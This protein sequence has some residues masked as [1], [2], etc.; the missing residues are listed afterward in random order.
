MFNFINCEKFN[1]YILTCSWKN[2]NDINYK[3][4]LQVFKYDDINDRLNPVLLFV[5]SS[6]II[7]RNI[8][9]DRH[10][11]LFLSGGRDLWLMRGWG[12]FHSWSTILTKTENGALMR[13]T[14]RDAKS[15][16]PAKML[17]TWPIRILP[18]SWSLTKPELLRSCLSSTFDSFSWQLRSNSYFRRL[19][20]QGENHFLL[21]LSKLSRQATL[22]D[23]I[24]GLTAIS[25]RMDIAA[26]PSH[27]VA[28]SINAFLAVTLKPSWFTSLEDST[29][30]PKYVYVLSWKLHPPR[31]PASSTKSCLHL[32][33]RLSAMV[34]TAVGHS[35]Y[36]GSAMW[37]PAVSRLLR[38]AMSARM[39]F[40][41]RTIP[42][43]SLLSV[44]Q[45]RKRA[46]RSSCWLSL[47]MFASTSHCCCC[48][49]SMAIRSYSI[50]FVLKPRA[51]VIWCDGTATSDKCRADGCRAQMWCC[52]DH[53]GDDGG[54]VVVLQH[55][56]DALHQHLSRRPGTYEERGIERNNRVL[57]NLEE[58]VSWGAEGRSRGSE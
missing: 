9:F 8:D 50:A 2:I 28:G 23:V 44:L 3:D 12:A 15:S 32:R 31:E 37:T 10:L 18:H 21:Q 7:V 29:A 33:Q 25:S 42:T 17:A 6:I 14:V 39:R 35:W 58:G 34:P 40:A 1:I 36:G 51:G 16:A 47:R 4:R 24:T 26:R 11:D 19:L 22:G 49:M 27:D 38:W 30:N 43:F 53:L 57:C 45:I 20:V 56:T 41:L 54:S 13:W 5:I 55:H 52:A 46:S 48:W